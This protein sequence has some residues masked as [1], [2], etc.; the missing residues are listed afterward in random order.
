MKKCTLGDLRKIKATGK[1]DE[2]ES[3]RLNQNS[4]HPDSLK[5]TVP[6]SI[7]KRIPADKPKPVKTEE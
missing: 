5:L 6:D 1:T 3:I 2:D 7:Y 4:E